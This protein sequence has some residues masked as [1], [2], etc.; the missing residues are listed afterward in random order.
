MLLCVKKCLYLYHQTIKQKKYI[1]KILVKPQI[2]LIRAKKGKYEVSVCLMKNN[3]NE[4]TIRAISHDKKD[5][6]IVGIVNREGK[7]IMRQTKQ[8][9]HEYFISVLD[10]HKKIDFLLD[11]VYG[12]KRDKFPVINKKGLTEFK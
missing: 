4:L 7:V 6:R 5:K 8:A 1:M 12:D 11:M 10:N 2:T 9:K 3:T